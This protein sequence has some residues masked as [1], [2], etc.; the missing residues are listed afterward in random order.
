MKD[1]KQTMNRFPAALV[2]LFTIVIFCSCSPE[3]EKYKTVTRGGLVYQRG[4]DEPFTGYVVGKGREDY[5]TT[6]C[7]YKKKYKNGL[8]NGDSKFWYP[9]GKLESVEPYHNGKINGSVIR[10][11]KTGR[12]KARISMI[13]GMRGG[14]KGELFW[15][16]KGKPIKGS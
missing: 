9:N 16:K 7:T 10:Y 11:Y 8:L 13:D 1:Q 2:I 5:R 4:Q 12:M 3:I 14:N 15:D 6:T